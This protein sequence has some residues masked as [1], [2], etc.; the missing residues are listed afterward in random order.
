MRPKENNKFEAERWKDSFNELL[1]FYSDFDSVKT[2]GDFQDFI[3]RQS[4]LV[5]SHPSNQW[6]GKKNL[7]SLEDHLRNGDNTAEMNNNLKDLVGELR[8]FP[9]EKPTEWKRVQKDFQNDVEKENTG[10]SYR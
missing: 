4:V 8:R 9:E 2:L 3:F 5:G 1:N 6:A 10:R 7:G